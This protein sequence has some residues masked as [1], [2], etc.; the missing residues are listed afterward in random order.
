MSLDETIKSVQESPQYQANI[1]SALLICVIFVIYTAGLDITACIVERNEK[2][3]PSYYNSNK[4]FF[5]ITITCLVIYCLFFI[6]GIVWF[7]FEIFTYFCTSSC[8]CPRTEECYKTI[9][10]NCSQLRKPE[11]LQQNEKCKKCVENLQTFSQWDNGR[12]KRNTLV[13]LLIA[14][15]A[16]LSFTAHFPS[17]LMAWATDPFYASRIALFYGIIIFCYFSAFHYTYIVS[18]RICFDDDKGNPSSCFPIV[19]SGSLIGSFL[20]VSAIVSIIAVYVI[21]VPV[22]NSIETATEGVT[23]IYNGAVVLIGGLVAYRIGW[24][25]IGS[26]FSVSDALEN[27]LKNVK[28]PSPTEPQHN[29]IPEDEKWDQLTEEGRLTEVMKAMINDELMKQLSKK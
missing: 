15:S 7:I 22:N 14:G 20:A 23:S 3:L 17:I 21:S 26:S 13:Y 2:G 29:T 6:L 11:C 18:F 28:F 25:Y 12:S 27:A 9:R 4:A 5:G 10:K 16:I 24:H 19:V 1:T 8:S